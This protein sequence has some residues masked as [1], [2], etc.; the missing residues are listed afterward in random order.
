MRK[1]GANKAIFRT[2]VCLGG[3]ILFL[4]F[5]IP[6][7]FGENRET[8]SPPPDAVRGFSYDYTAEELAFINANPKI[9]VSNEFDW[10]PF[11]F[12]ASGKPAGFGID[13]MELLSR[14]SGLTF[15]YVNGYTWDELTQM[16]FN[17]NKIDL[18]HSLSITPERQKKALFSA[19]YYHSKNV[20]VYRSDTHD[21]HS[22]ND[23][24]G[25]I[26][27]LPKGWSS[28]EF[29]KTHYPRVHI[30]EVESSRQALEYIDNGKVVATVEQE[31]IAQYFITKFGFSDLKLSKWIENEELQKTSSMHFAVGKTNPILFSILD[32]ALS[33]VTLAEIRTLKEKWFSQAGRQIGANDV[34]LTP[35]EK[36][37]LK[38][39]KKVLYCMVQE[40]MPFSGLNGSRTTGISPD[41]MELFSER[42]GVEFSYFPVTNFNQTI[43]SLQKGDCDIIPLISRTKE[44]QKEFG[45]T[46]GYTGYNVAIIARENAQFIPGIPVLANL[47]IGL[48]PTSNIFEKII[49]K[50]PKLKFTPVETIEGCLKKVSTGQ[51]DAAILSLPMAS[52]YIRQNGL[53][54]LK[55]AG[56]TSIKEDLRIATLKENNLLHTIL[57][58]VVRSLSNQ[59]LESIDTKW[60]TIKMGESIDYALI[61]KILGVSGMILA[62]VV[63]WN[64]KLARFNKEIASANS[65]LKE[66][67]KELEYISITD[68]L[69]HLHNRRYVEKAF[70]LELKRSIRHSRDLSL[71]IIDI[72]FFKAINDTYGHQVGDEVLKS[73]AALMKASIRATDIL[74]RWGGEEF[75]IVCPEINIENAVKMAKGL[76][77]KVAQTSFDAAGTQTASFGVTGFKK[78]D[79]TQSMILRADNAL[80]QAKSKGR[81]RVESLM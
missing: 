73:F 48:V 76:C 45:F 56:H 74:G 24:D 79:D 78:G 13:L 18:I 65:L 64:R 10:P 15:T 4:M 43:S 26:I 44:R 57:S 27:A 47:K 62:G 6:P 63:F 22:L 58:K 61:W 60:M 71:I 69:T 42:L 49:A 50:Y 51:L 28:I 67:T 52:Y 81:N 9:R 31:G 55:V 5:T 33:N 39:K 34:G 17:E 66:K 23:L 19:P 2:I 59:E 46:A 54:N 8:S 68:S 29:F 14:K 30:I 70:E 72:D 77:L 80:Y 21:L 36:K 12:V 1:T 3:L 53:T 25:K 35:E 16:F 7:A 41:L 40:R 75:I 11:D 32:K 37:W 38:N 20:M